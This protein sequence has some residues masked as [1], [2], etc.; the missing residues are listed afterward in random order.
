MG[1]FPSGVF[2]FLGLFGPQSAIQ[3]RTQSSA[4][5]SWGE[6]NLLSQQVCAVQ[7]F[8]T[9]I[10]FVGCLPFIGLCSRRIV[11]IIVKWC[12]F[13]PNTFPV[14]FSPALVGW[15]MPFGVHF[16]WFG[17]EQPGHMSGCYHLFLSLQLG[18]QSLESVWQFPGPQV[19][20]SLYFWGILY[21]DAGFWSS[22]VGWLLFRLP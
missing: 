20:A 14:L 1:L 3:G 8:F 13:L 2:S 5:C 4:W 22:V 6:V 19:W 9:L 7:F 11:Y 17:G 15:F 21:L 18:S 10:V 12:F 16:I